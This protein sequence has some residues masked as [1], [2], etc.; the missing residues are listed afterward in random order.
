[1]SRSLKKGPYI[2]EKLLAKVQQ[3]NE[4]NEKKVIKT[5]SRRSTIFP[6]MVGHTLAVHDGRKHVPVYITEDMVGHKLGEF[7]PTR[8]YRGHGGHTE[9]STSLK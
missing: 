4:K 7:A 3:M 9:R 8:T 1:M 6:E 5:W 2:E